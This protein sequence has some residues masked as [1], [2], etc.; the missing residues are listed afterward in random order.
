VGVAVN[1]DDAPPLRQL[2]REKLG[3]MPAA[4]AHAEYSD[5]AQRLRDGAQH[6]R[7]WWL[8]H[9]VVGVVFMVLGRR[10]G[11]GDGVPEAEITG[12]LS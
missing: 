1:G 3:G 5:C 6:L 9:D 12:S 8:S 10:K 7:C 4:I 11:A 2:R